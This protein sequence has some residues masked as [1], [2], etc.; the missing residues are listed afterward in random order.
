MILR[1]RKIPARSSKEPNTPRK[2]AESIKILTPQSTS[3]GQRRVQLKS[4]TVHNVTVWNDAV[5]SSSKKHTI[6]QAQHLH[7]FIEDEDLRIPHRHRSVRVHFQLDESSPGE[8]SISSQL[9]L[10]SSPINRSGNLLD[11]YSPPN[12]TAIHQNSIPDYPYFSEL[13]EEEARENFNPYKFIC[14][15]QAASGNLRKR[16]SDI[17]FKTRSAPENTL[18]L[19]LE[20]L[21]ESSLLPLPD[22][23]F[24]FLTP[25]Q[26][27]YYK[28]YLNLR[29]HVREFLDKLCKIY[30]IFVFTT[31]KKEYAE[32]ILEILDPQKKL[33]R[34][35]LYQDHC[36]CVSGHYVKDLNVLHRDLAKTVALDTLAYTLP[37]HNSGKALDRKLYR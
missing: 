13:P 8:A 27:T 37:F 9:C 18:V 20:V 22:A 16:K 28:V 12:H 3:R 4:P 17:P 19:D 2:R 35:R 7:N 33:I 6:R 32:K 36:A 5:T 24:T 23:E 26:D 29:P 30:E 34:H 1:S 15:A 21:V 11:D 14:S 31:A 25:F 10:Y